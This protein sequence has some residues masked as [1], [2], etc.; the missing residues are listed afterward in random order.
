MIM[1]WDVLTL[2]SGKDGTQVASVRLQDCHPVA[3]LQVVDFS[4]DGWNDVII[5]CPDK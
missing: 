4:G 3:P 2:L 1:G 5:T